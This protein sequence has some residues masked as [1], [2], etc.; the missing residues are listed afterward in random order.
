MQKFLREPYNK[1]DNDNDNDDDDDKLPKVT[2]RM[3]LKTVF[4]ISETNCA[5]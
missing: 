5:I 3:S 2:Q 4:L 1:N